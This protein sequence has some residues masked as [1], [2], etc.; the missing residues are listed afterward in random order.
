MITLSDQEF[1]DIIAV[2]LD[3]LPL[4]YTDKLK[5]VLITYADD[6]SI[7]QRQKLHLRCNESLFGLYE[8]IPLTQKAEANSIFSGRA[9]YLPDRIT[10]FKNPITQHSADSESLKSQVKHTL[11]HEIAHY[12]GLDH[13][14]IH[15]IES[16][17]R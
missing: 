6:P 17:W 7:D 8:G 4:E 10:I 5:N 2:C 3:E 12:F 9:T 13:D 14:K 15:S 16:T 1:N 11:W